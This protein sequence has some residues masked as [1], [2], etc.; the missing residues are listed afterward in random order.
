[1]AIGGTFKTAAGL[2]LDFDNESAN[3]GACGQLQGPAH[4]YSVTRGGEELQV[5]IMTDPKPLVVMLGTDGRFSG[6]A[7]FDLSGDVIVGY[8]T[9]WVE[10]ERVTTLSFPEAGI[11]NECRCGTRR[12]RLEPARDRDAGPNARTTRC[13]AH[14]SAARDAACRRRTSPS[15]AAGASPPPN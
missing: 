7:A 4:G 13:V 9:Y 12:Y 5:E 15:R 10:C 1:M 3:I 8:N 14:Q 2:G 6:P 11:R